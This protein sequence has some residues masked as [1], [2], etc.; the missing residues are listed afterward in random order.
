MNQ[1]NV[2]FY[3]LHG[4]AGLSCVFYETLDFIPAELT[5]KSN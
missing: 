3:L 4:G 2:K 1:F 5:G